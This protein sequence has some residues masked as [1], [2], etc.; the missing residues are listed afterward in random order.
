MPLIQARVRKRNQ[1]RSASAPCRSLQSVISHRQHCHKQKCARAKAKIQKDMRK[2]ADGEPPKNRDI[3]RCLPGR[4]LDPEDPEHPLAHGIALFGR[5][6]SRPMRKNEDHDHDSKHGNYP[7]SELEILSMTYICYFFHKKVAYPRSLPLPTIY[8]I[9]SI[10][11]LIPSAKLVCGCQ[12]IA[13]TR[14][15]MSGSRLTMGVCVGG[16]NS[17]SAPFP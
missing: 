15:V 14:L 11:F 4:D 17:H 9:F 3:G 10:I 7:E 5:R 8:E 6:V 12:S 1:Q 13:S 2:F 16:A